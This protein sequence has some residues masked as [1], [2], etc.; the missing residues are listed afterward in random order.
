LTLLL[1]AICIT[2]NYVVIGVRFATI[3]QKCGNRG[4]VLPQ[5]KCIAIFTFGVARRETYSNPF[6]KSVAIG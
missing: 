2:K 1:D 6:L 3:V 4:T 5:K